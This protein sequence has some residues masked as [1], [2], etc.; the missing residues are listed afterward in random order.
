MTRKRSWE[1]MTLQMAQMV[2]F[3]ENFIESLLYFFNTPMPLLILIPGPACIS[4]LLRTDEA[5]TFVHLLYSSCYMPEGS[6]NPSMRIIVCTLFL[7]MISFSRDL[8]N[9]L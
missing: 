8:Q 7:K 1:T 3:P 9:V 4:E 6:F 2:C 5:R